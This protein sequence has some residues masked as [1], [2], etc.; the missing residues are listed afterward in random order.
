MHKKKGITWTARYLHLCVFHTIFFYFCGYVCIMFALIFLLVPNCGTPSNYNP[1]FL[2]TLLLQFKR[3]V[4][5]YYITIFF[6]KYF[7]FCLENNNNNWDWTLSRM[8]IPNCPFHQSNTI[9]GLL[10]RCLRWTGPYL[11]S[12]HFFFSPL[13]TTLFI[14]HISSSFLPQTSLPLSL[15]LSLSSLF[16]FKIQIRASKSLSEAKHNTLRAY[17]HTQHSYVCSSKSTQL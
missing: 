8:S 5:I 6:F 12:E 16:F 10:S 3:M 4:M 1:F 9:R 13:P 11:T 2:I 17:I 15:S 7:S 14:L